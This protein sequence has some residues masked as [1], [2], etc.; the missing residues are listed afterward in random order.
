M[1]V[2]NPFDWYWIDAN[3]KIFSSSARAL[4]EASNAA[5]EA[6]C[7]AGNVATPWPKDA[8]GAQTSAA[9]DAV[10]SPYNLSTG[11]TPL[12]TAQLLAYGDQTLQNFLGLG[13]SVNLGTSAAPVTVLVDGTQQT[14]ANLALAVLW[15]QANPK[16]TKSWVDNT[17]T[18]NVL[19]AAQIQ[20]MAT[21][22]GNWTDNCWAAYGALAKQIIN[23][24]ITTYAQI[25]AYAW[26]T[27]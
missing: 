5:Y 17:N 11:L 3:G 26:P 10:L 1:S 14:I 13:I 21:A 16:G 27:S 15:S 9:L 8:S 6:W 2:Y 24:S 7:K 19:N 12:T 22:V 4:V 25:D 23:A 20:A 18:T